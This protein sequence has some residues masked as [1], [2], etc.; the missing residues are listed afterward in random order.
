MAYHRNGYKSWKE[1][2]NNSRFVSSFILF[3]KYGIDNCPIYLLESVDAKSYD[4]LLARE[5][6]FIKT[7]KCINKNIPSRTPKE[8]RDENKE[9][10]KEKFDIYYKNN[11]DKISMQKKEYKKWNEEKFKEYSKQYYND[12][13]ETF[14]KK[15]KENSEKN[16]DKV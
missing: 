13:R 4:E 11:F 16:V 7:L 15:R 8:W 2:K 14:L 10:F 6:Y 3:D 9:I 5:G 1:G 12:N